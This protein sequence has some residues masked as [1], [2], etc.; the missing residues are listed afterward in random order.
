MGVVIFWI[1][2]F[3]VWVVI[4]VKLMRRKEDDKSVISKYEDS[5]GMEIR[6]RRDSYEVNRGEEG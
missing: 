5:A 3:L 1:A 4:V 2:V 6:G